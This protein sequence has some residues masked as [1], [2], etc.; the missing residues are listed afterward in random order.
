M[1]GTR[2]RLTSSA[3]RPLHAWQKPC[4]TTTVF[5][6][7]RTSRWGLAWSFIH[8]GAPPTVRAHDAARCTPRTPTPHPPGLALRGREGCTHQT[9]SSSADV[10]RKRAA[11]VTHTVRLP[12]T[13]TA[14]VVQKEL[15]DLLTAVYAL[16]VQAVEVRPP[17]KAGLVVG[18]STLGHGTTGRVHPDILCMQTRPP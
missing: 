16:H 5:R 7:G 12:A 15:L 14:D 6:Q 1:L 9:T 3:V 2:R 13:T 18:E 17:W 4:W 10:G 8:K 11:A